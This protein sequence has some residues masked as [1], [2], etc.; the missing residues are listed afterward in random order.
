MFQTFSKLV[1]T[2]KPAKQEP[3]D[4]VPIQTSYI[5]REVSIPHDFLQKDPYD[6]KPI[7]VSHINWSTS[8]LPQNEG[9]Y[10]V[11]LD[12]V[13]SPSEC[14]QLLKLA[15]ASVVDPADPNAG[16][17][18]RPAL[19]NIGPGWEILHKSYRNSDRIIW[20]N[21]EV[22]DRLWE[23]CA[24][25]PGIKEELAEVVEGLSERQKKKGWATGQKWEFRR[26]NARM[27]FLKYQG[28]QFFRRESSPFSL[29]LCSYHSHELT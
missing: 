19:V 23:R 22:M 9:R 2:A 12:N 15:E 14:A 25:A 17:A 7:T 1:A 5:S 13:L 18:W 6:A 27:R 26:F 24:R 20:D 11:V 16:E 29:T 21:Q 8:P 3:Q 28:G 4:G 10:A